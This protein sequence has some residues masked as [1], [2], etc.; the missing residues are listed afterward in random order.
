MQE[1]CV[2]LD[3]TCS[4]INTERC[5]LKTAALFKVCSNDRIVNSLSNYVSHYNTAKIPF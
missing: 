2:C 5:F 4:R 3:G 1:R